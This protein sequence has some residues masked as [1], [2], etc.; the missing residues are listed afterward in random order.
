MRTSIVKIVLTS[1][2]LFALGSV[3]SQV[4]QGYYQVRRGDTI[5]RIALNNGISPRD[6]IA[7][8]RLTPST[9]LDVGQIISLQPQADVSSQPSVSSLPPPEF[10]W[11]IKGKVLLGFSDVNK[12][13]DIA[14]NIGQ[15]VTASASGLVVYSGNT[16]RGYGNLIIIKHD[17]TYLSAY[18]FNR[19]LLVKE[20]DSVK[21][22]QMIAEV[23]EFEESGPKLHF[24]IRVNGK[25]VNPEPFLNGT[26]KKQVATPSNIVVSIDDA[27]NKC[28]ELGFKSGTQEFGKCVLQLSK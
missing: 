11:P 9:Q 22:G 7:W 2:S 10:I 6:L 1:F 15:P 5:A 28:N 20:G 14:G 24:E 25:P 12:G 3:Y 8:N 21:Q 18:A 13:I 4:P 26:I 17:N 19:V 23:G 16:L 27:K